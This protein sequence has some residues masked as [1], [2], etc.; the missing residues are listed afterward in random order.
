MDDS[1]SMGVIEGAGDLNRRRE[2]LLKRHM[3]SRQAGGQ[4]LAF[5]VFHDEKVGS[6][7]M[8]DVVQGADVR[9][10]Q[11]RDRARLA[12]EALT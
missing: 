2:P 10:I 12:L 11:R 3:A 4:R 8:S 9:M 1:V 5:Q 6:I 7:L